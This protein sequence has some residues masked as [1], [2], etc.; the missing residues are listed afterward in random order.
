MAGTSR[1]GSKFGTYHEDKVIWRLR[2]VVLT[3]TCKNGTIQFDRPLPADLEGKQIQVTILVTR[4]SANEEVKP[5]VR[6]R[7][8]SG[9]AKGQIRMSPDFDAPLDDF[10]EYMA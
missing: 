4:G 9:S 2:M 5:L 6:K 8:Q 10:Q 1:S 3:A 7:R